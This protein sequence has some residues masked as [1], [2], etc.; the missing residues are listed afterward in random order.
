M[1][2]APADACV[3]LIVLHPVRDVGDVSSE[4]IANVAE[5]ARVIASNSEKERPAA[6]V[7]ILSG[8]LSMGVCKWVGFGGRSLFH[9]VG[10]RNPFHGKTTC[11][12]RPLGGQFSWKN[13]R[14]PRKVYHGDPPPP[15]Q[16]LSYHGDH[17]PKKYYHPPLPR[18]SY[19]SD[20]L[21]ILSL[22]TPTRKIY[23]GDPLQTLS[24]TT[25]LT[26][27]HGVRSPRPAKTRGCTV[28]HGRGK[29]TRPRGAFFHGRGKMARPRGGF[30]HGRGKTHLLDFCFPRKR[31]GTLVPG[32]FVEEL[33]PPKKHNTCI[34]P[35]QHKS[36]AQSHRPS[37]L[38]APQPLGVRDRI[39][40][41]QSGQRQRRTACTNHPCWHTSNLRRIALGGN[42]NQVS[43]ERP[44][45]DVIPDL[46]GT[47]ARTTRGIV[48]HLAQ[49]AVLQL[50]RS[51][52]SV[53][54]VDSISRPREMPMC[55]AHQDTPRLQHVWCTGL[56]LRQNPST[57]QK[58]ERAQQINSQAC[59]QQAVAKHAGM[60]LGPS[61]NQRAGLAKTPNRKGYE[62]RLDSPSDR[63][64]IR[65]KFQTSSQTAATRLDRWRSWLFFLQPFASIAC[66]P[67]SY[68]G[69]V[70][71]LKLELVKD[72]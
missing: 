24:R 41:L 6:R 47:N 45:Q 51:K 7:D 28:F 29:M 39:P 14:P 4:A 69:P 42:M 5:N 70:A 50:R 56:M 46:R 30:F 16:D 37:V 57:N 52:G 68:R 40:E 61:R 60:E 49:A 59:C 3:L 64:L 43:R 55:A 27:G 67:D 2:K 25:C 15:L 65:N 21:Q 8:G 38:P 11:S 20:P 72:D 35:A 19:H 10:S 26:A 12:P 32:A 36:F 44:L 17:P 62:R 71:R 23:H 33:S 18:K 31:P 9:E 63:F 48:S 53:C 13:T 54:C 1:H 22:R 66:S 34:P 58:S